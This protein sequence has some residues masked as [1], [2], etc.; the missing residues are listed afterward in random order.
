MSGTSTPDTMDK[1]PERRKLIAVVYAD[2]VGYSRLIGLDDV[3]TLQRLRTL[4]RTLIDPAIEEYGGRIVN[5]GG[6]SLLMVFD[7]I[8]GAVRCAVKVQQQVSAHDGDIPP[9]RAIRF[10]VGINVGD[11]IPDGADVHGDVV[12]VAARLQAE[13][14]PGGICVTRQVRDHVQDRLDLVFEELGTLNLKNIA[15]P[16]EAYAVRLDDDA[17][18]PRPV[19]PFREERGA[20]ALPP[21]SDAMDESRRSFW[22][23]AWTLWRNHAGRPVAVS[24]GSRAGDGRRR[25][26]TRQEAGHAAV[27]VVHPRLS[28][29]VLPFENLNGEPKDDYLADAITDDLTSDL[30]LVPDVSVMARETANAYRGQPKDVKRIGEELRVRYVL[31]GNVRNLGST[32]RVNVQMISGETG[33]LLWSDRFDEEIGNL[34]AGQEQVVRRMKDEVG[35]R[36]IEIE[37]ARSLRERPTNPDAFDLVLRVRSIRNQPTSVQR[38]DEA[39]ALLERA[40]VLD[41]SSVYAMTHI[42][43]YLSNAAGRGDGWEDFECMQRAGRLLAQ[44]RAIAPDSPVVLNGYVLWLRTVGRYAEA[45]EAC[46]RAIQ[47]HP[48]RIRGLSGIYHELGRCKTWTGHAEEGITLEEEAN[49]LNPYSPWRYV[50]YRHIGWYSLLLGKDLDAIRYLERSHT[51]NPED[52]GTTHLQY[53]RLAAAYAR[54][55]KIEEARQYLVGADRLW[56]YDTARSRA[57]EILLNPTYIEQFRQFQDALRLAGLRDHA[58]EDADFGLPTFAALRGRLAG[59]T[60]KDALGVTTLHTADLV[61][62]LAE[63]EPIV[64]DTMMYFWGQSISGAVGLKYAG[65]GG[66]FTDEAQDRLRRKMQELTSGD[67]SLPIVA[68]GWNSER[69]DGCNLALRLVALGYTK[70]YWYRGGR[71]A[72]EVNGLPETA[73]DAQEW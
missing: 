12:N 47:V 30:S 60:P 34:A 57:P 49:R 61:Q 67:M 51:I 71:E 2:V 53:R 29:V 73:L 35:I 8:D 10:R 37:N 22:Q 15:R 59:L 39:L 18:A 62:F 5:T 31:K 55:G 44:A 52:D 56:P 58:A 41:P 20:I 48:N 13:C 42:A 66:C 16:V 65:L 45:V 24:A 68:V 54:I 7:S 6:D 21:N 38:D 63:S 33:A 9:D 40:F 4:R 19:A 25:S 69:F 27:T 23:T 50:R 32:F 36:L 17:T 14:P 1:P 64:I 28:I 43:F 3:G 11:V 26:V 70:V 72:W 46:E